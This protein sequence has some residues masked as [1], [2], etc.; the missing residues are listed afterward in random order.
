MSE[1]CEVVIHADD[2]IGRDHA[3]MLRERLLREG[4]HDDVV[5]VRE[6]SADE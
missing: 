2:G 1:R 4:F 6:V 3:E 5:S